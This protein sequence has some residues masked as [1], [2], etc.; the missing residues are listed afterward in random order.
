[1]PKFDKYDAVIT[2]AGTDLFLVK[3]GDAT[4]IMTL[5]QIEEFYPRCLPLKTGQVTSYHTGDDGDL[6]KG[7][8]RSYNILTAGQYS[9]TTN[10]VING[11]THALSN[12]CVIDERT[13]LMWARYVPD[14][15]IGPGTDGKLF[16]DQWT[17]ED[18]TD[19]SFDNATGEIRSGASE[20][21]TG[22]LCAGRKFTVTGSTSNDGTYTVSSITTAAITTVEGVE[23]AA[24]DTV[25]IET[26]DDLIW[27]FRDQ[28]NANS[29]GGYTDWRIPSYSE[30]P[31]LIDLGESNPCIDTTAFPSTPTNYHWLSST[32]PGY[33]TYAFS[34]YFSSGHV[35]SVNKDSRRYYVR[36]VRG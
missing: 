29:L 19:I 11:K 7:V 15:D 14:A 32:R 13:G 33:P 10:I 34:V 18:K 4:K 24:G 9:G 31:K 22:A 30:L 8:S 26:V 28:A 6:E 16:W 3:Q 23:E 5:S 27:D 12:N 21:D 1:M 35:N 2:P 20:F 25:T 17:L 36:L